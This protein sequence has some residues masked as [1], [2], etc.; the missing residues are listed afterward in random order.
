MRALVSILIPTD[1]AED[2]VGAAIDSALGQTWR[3]RDHCRR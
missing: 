3:R 2:W 1:N